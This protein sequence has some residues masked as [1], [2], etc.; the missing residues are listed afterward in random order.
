MG[1]S[2][3]ITWERDGKCFN[4]PH[5]NPLFFSNMAEDQARAKRICTGCPVRSQCF[6]DGYIQ[7]S[8]GIQGGAD[9]PERKLMVL[10]LGFPTLDVL[11]VR[12]DTIFLGREAETHTQSCNSS[13]NKPISE[14]DLPLQVSSLQAKRA[15]HLE[16]GIQQIS[17]VQL[18][19][20]A[21]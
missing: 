17:E 3:A 12:L 10:V 21:V 6:I 7:D 11:R 13:L 8:E 5:L 15:E 14:L 16:S 9:R 18:N 2:I 19:L 1:S 4:K 20:V